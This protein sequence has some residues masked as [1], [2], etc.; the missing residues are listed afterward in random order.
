MQ[1]TSFQT[2]NNQTLEIFT[3]KRSGCFEV[4]IVGPQ[5]GRRTILN[6]YLTRDNLQARLRYTKTELPAWLVAQPDSL[7]ELKSAFA[8][9]DEESLEVGTFWDS[10]ELSEHLGAVAA[11][12]CNQTTLEAAR[13]DLVGYWTDGSS[14]LSFGPDASFSA[15]L[16]PNPVHPFLRAVAKS[17]PDQWLLSESWQIRVMNRETRKAD[18]T[19]VHR[20]LPA[21]L[22]LGGTG[23]CIAYVFKRPAGSPVASG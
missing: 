23:N 21:E 16:A 10:P 8:L 3:E 9:K 22:H 14:T 7:P 2:R 19:V 15:S 18:R 6:H 17:C 4:W 5:E 13:A 11:L 12:D 20:V 1:T